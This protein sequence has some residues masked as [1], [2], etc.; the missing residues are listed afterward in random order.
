MLLCF[1][2]FQIQEYSVNLRLFSGRIATPRLLRT[3]KAKTSGSYRAG[4]C[5][6]SCFLVAGE[7]TLICS[8]FKPDNLGSFQIGLHYSSSSNNNSSGREPSICPMP[9]PYAVPPDPRLFLQSIRGP[10]AA[11][12]AAR[13]AWGR[14]ALQIAAAPTRVSSSTIYINLYVYLLYTLLQVYVS[15]LY[16]DAYT[17][18]NCFCVF[19]VGSYI[20]LRELFLCHLYLRVYCGTSYTYRIYLSRCTD[21]V[22]NPVLYEVDLYICV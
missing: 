8:T 12:R 21:F 20:R 16:I 4:C 1:F 18:M 2:S 6:L 13:H 5:V 19:V 11:A 17:Y 10:S 3:G 7:Y 22:R 15:Y 9:Y 14:V